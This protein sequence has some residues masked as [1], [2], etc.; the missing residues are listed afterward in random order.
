MI[1]AVVVPAGTAGKEYERAATA[2]L[3]DCGCNPQSI[4]E[5]ACSRAEELRVSLAQDAASGK[6]G[7]AII[8]AYVAKHGQKIL[9]SP[10]ASGFNLIAWTGP[11]IGLLGAAVMIAVMLRRWRRV[12]AALPEEA[13]PSVSASDDAY[14]A[15]L[16]KEVEEGR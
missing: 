6:T 11:A 5:C 7:D 2:L 12:S 9:V 13:S 10:P 16:R 4:K 14:L 3:C 8:A 15:R 1:L